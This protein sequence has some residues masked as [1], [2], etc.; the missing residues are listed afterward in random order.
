MLE[1]VLAGSGRGKG[2]EVL[3]SPAVFH[4][5]C[6][7]S[8]WMS[9]AQ[10]GEGEGKEGKE[11]KEGGAARKD[12]LEEI[13]CLSLL[14]FSAPVDLVK[15]RLQNQTESFGNQARPGHLQARYQGPVHCAVCIFREEGIFGLY[16]GCLA[17]ALRDIPSMGLYFLTYEVLCKWMTKS[18]DEPSAWT[19]LFAGGCAGTVGWA[20]ANPMDVIKARLQMDGMHGVQYLG[21]LDCIRKSIRQEGVKVFLKGL[22]INSLRAFPVN[23]VTFLS[24]E[25]LLKAFR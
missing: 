4:S 23:A 13:C 9:F 1:L 7:L 15:V 14:S 22:T 16:R 3:L 19:M 24:Y 6:D 11:R 10:R 17:L 21:M 2:E 5:L 25:M 18:L 8:L 20:F 12:E